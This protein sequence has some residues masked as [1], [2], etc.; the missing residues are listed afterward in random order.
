MKNMD[1]I[2]TDSQGQIIIPSDMR[3]SLMEGCEIMVVGDNGN[4]VIRKA[5][6]TEK[7]KED[8]EFANGTKEA[9]KE[10]EKGKC[11]SM[12]FDE[13]IEEMKKW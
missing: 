6:L 10:I 11:T 12:E 4:F 3:N 7:M 13:F 8:L 9:W 5:A 1:I 2:K